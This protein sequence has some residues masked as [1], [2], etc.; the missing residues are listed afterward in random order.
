M[1]MGKRNL[2]KSGFVIPVIGMGTWQTFDVSGTA[3][4]ENCKEVVSTAYQHGATFYDSSPM[5]GEAERVL[6]NA[7]IDL[8]L[9]EKVMIATKVWTDDDAQAAKQFE[10]SFKYFGGYVDLYQVHNL[11][12]WKK[13]LTQLEKFKDEG[14]IK[15]IGI[16][17]YQHS[18]FDDIKQIMKTGRIDSIQIPYNALDRLAENELLPLAADLNIGVIVMRP[19]GVGELVRRAPV[20]TELAVFEEF[21]VKT[22]PQVLLKWI[23]SDERITVAIPATSS[24]KHM[25]ENIVAGSA[26]WFDKATRE[27]VSKLAKG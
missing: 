21:G 18:A 19:L 20:A 6:G 1:L 12:A 26:P 4:E 24:P 27:R 9:R 22:W 23:L 25:A 14:K 7:V 11:V 8:G 17:H 5:Y 15:A 3:E 13:R 16:T 10:N 2:G